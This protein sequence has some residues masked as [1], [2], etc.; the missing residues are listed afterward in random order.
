MLSAATNGRRL[1][2]RYTLIE[3]LGAGG[4]GE[5]WRARDESRGV[6]LALKVLSPS[7]A[8]SDAAW[9]ALERE[10]EVASKLD[11]PSI[12]KVHPPQRD[13]ESAV[14]PMEIATGGDLRRL[15]GASYLE[16]V[17]ALLEIAHALDHAHERGI[18]HRDLKP[19]NVLFDSRGRVRLADF[20]VAAGT[21][22]S[23]QRDAIRSGMSPFT[24]S[25]EQLRGESPAVS[26]D[27]Y[28]LGALAYELLS[29]YPPYYPK[30]DLKRVLEEPVPEIRPVHQAPPRLI[31]LVM[32]ML[33]KKPSL[34]PHTMRDVIDDLDATLNDTLTF[35][36]DDEAATAENAGVDD[37]SDED[38]EEEF[39][40]PAPPPVRAAPE[41]QRAA[42]PVPQRPAPSV[43]PPAASSP[44]PQARA[45]A[46]ESARAP[47]SACYL[48]HRKFIR[49]ISFNSKIFG[50]S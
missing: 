26:D 29:G 11:H 50:A 5:V 15:R 33:A 23:S 10:Y 48:C 46:P 17:P 13:A 43:S 27:V 2:G 38:E 18:V 32:A 41:Q 16:I 34:R 35:D 45:P 7:L 21:A 40:E 39:F 22:L 37:S 25:P 12:L 47:S 1:C 28:G 3:K 44:P 31:A 9:M 42:P 4:Q 24:A 30:F 8:R 49:S 20:G 19:S 6:D 36:F 14:L